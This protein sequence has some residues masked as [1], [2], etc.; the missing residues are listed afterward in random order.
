MKEL[1]SLASDLGSLLPPKKPGAEGTKFELGGNP[2]GDPLID[3][4]KKWIMIGLVGL[5]VGGAA[6]LII[7]S[8]YNKIL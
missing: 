6:I 7:V 8:I 2:Q 4:M 1:N 5:V 3:K